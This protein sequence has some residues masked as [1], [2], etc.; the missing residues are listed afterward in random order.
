[1]DRAL[2]GGA[3]EEGVERLAVDGVLAGAGLE[4]DSRDSGLALAGGAVARAGGEVDRRV[5]DRLGQ[6]L[7][8]LRGA[9]GGLL[10][11]L[12]LAVARAGTQRLL[13]LPDDVDLE[14]HAGDRRLLTR[15][16][17]AVLDVRFLLFR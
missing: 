1:A 2:Q 12:V 17:L 6:L 3:R 14:V 11:V 15:R 9:L 7:L 5:G 13:A 8:G 16:L 10:V 4:R